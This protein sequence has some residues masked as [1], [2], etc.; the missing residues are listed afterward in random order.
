MAKKKTE[1][2]PVDASPALTVK[3]AAVLH[4]AGTTYQ[5]GDTFETTTDRAAAL[6]ELVTPA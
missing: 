5:P 3:A 6:G 1:E 4:E 2:T